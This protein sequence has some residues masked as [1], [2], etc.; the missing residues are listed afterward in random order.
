MAA[1]VVGTAIAVLLAA[2]YAAWRRYLWASEQDPEQLPDTC[3]YSLTDR[4]GP[5]SLIGAPHQKDAQWLTDIFSRSAKKY[6]NH[7]ALQI[8]LTGEQFTFAELDARAENI[9]AELSR[10]IDGPDQ[11]VAVAMSQDNWHIVAS[12]LAILKAGGTL[13]FLD[14]TLPESLI[15]H[16]LDDAKPVVILTRGLEQFRDLPTLDVL[17]VSQSDP[18]ADR[19]LP[20]WLDDPRERLATIFY[21]S[22][23]T[24]MPKGVECPHAGYVNLALTYAD[25][26]D[27]LPGMDATTLT[28]SL[29]YDGSISEMY[30]AWV[31]GCTVVLLTKEQVR[32]GPD[33][34]PILREAEVTVLFCPPVLL[35]T[36]TANPEIDL[37][38][39]I[40]RYIVP[41]GEAFPNALVE[42]WTRA[43]RQIINTYGPTEASTDTSRQ[44]LRPGEPI[45]IGSPFPNV[46]YVILEVDGLTP[47]PHGAEGELCIGGVHLAR[48]YRNLPE[49]TAQKF[50]THPQ[51]GRLYR[52]GDRCRIDPET[53]Q[54]H[55]LGRIDA[56]LKVRGH[57]VEAQA[58]EDIL[59]SQF[60]EI[61]AAVLD[62]QNEALVAF[63]LA[64]GVA[65]GPRPISVA[66]PAPADWAARVTAILSKQLPETS[67]PS[68]LFLVDGFVMKPVSGKIDR[69][70][71]PKLAALP[72]HAEPVAEAISQP[73]GSGDG[74]LTLTKPDVARITEIPPDAEE[75]LEICRSVFENNIELDDAFADAG[76][77]SIVIAR[78]AQRLHAA[79]WTIPVRALLSDCNTARKI[80]QRPRTQ[81]ADLEIISISNRNDGKKRIRDEAAAEVLSIPYFTALQIAFALLLYLPGFVAFLSL[82]GFLEI[83]TF[84]TSANIWAFI[85]VGF[86]VFVIGLA[87]PFAT[88]LWAM[89]VKLLLGGHPY[90]NNV[91]P[92]VY[93][94]WSRMHLRIWCIGRIQ[95]TVLMPL[96]AM[97][98]SAPLMAFALRQ[99][100]ATVGKNLQC[101]KEAAFYGPLDLISVGDDVAIQTGAYIHT[102]RWEGQ[103]LHV[104]PIRLDD[105]CKISMRAG[106]TS[107]VTI[108]KDAWITP[109][110]PIMSNVGPG[111]MWEGSPARATGR[112]V[113]LKRTSNVC[114]YT[115][116][117]WLLEV[118]NVFMQ[119]GIFFVLTVLPT[120]V[121][122]W[123]A[124]QFIPV[125][126][127]ELS[128]ASFTSFVATDQ[129]AA[130][131]T[132]GQG[133]VP[134]NYFAVTPLY[135]I[136]GHLALYAFATMW[137][138]IVT[139]SALIALFVRVTATSPGVYGVRGLRASLLIYRMGLLNQIQGIWTWTITGQYLRALAGLRFPR[140][141]ASEC[142]VMFNLVPEV[143]TAD[144]QVF[145]SNGSFT[146]TLDYGAEHVA[147]RQIDMPRNFFSG[148]NCVIEHG[149]FPDNFL[150]GVSTPCSDIIYRRQMRSRRA[151]PVTVAGNPPLQFASAS[152]EDENRQHRPPG[153]SLFLGRVLLNDVFSIG[154]LR[155]TEGLIFT[156]LYISLMRLGIDA[157]VGAVLALILAETGL[158]ILSVAVKQS[159]V[160][161]H[162]GTNHATPFWSWRHFT[163]FFAQDCFF[164]WCQGPLAF[165]AGTVLA[166]RVL[167]WLG[168]KVGPRTIVVDPMQCS[169]WNAVRF[170]DDCVVGG[171]LQFHTF[172]N[173][174]LKVKETHVGDGSV[175]AFGATVMSGAVIGR[176][177]TLQPL[178]MVLKEMNL[179]PGLYE[180]SPAEQS[181]PAIDHLKREAK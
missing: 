64:P 96:G 144:S 4:F 115:L 18:P 9:A 149:G 131:T 105:G 28:S 106:V 25:Y 133:A 93:P 107:E 44:S 85:I 119:I 98:R 127:A 110:T 12:H 38:Y 14:T 102:A 157:I 117:V 33:L 20:T 109:F 171:F 138:T 79:G 82:F 95:N 83:G 122:L 52:T 116:P 132:A 58:V 150:I 29:G 101:A 68:R 13:M 47:L 140:L 164:V 50:I 11:V 60:R 114:Q 46:T 154:L 72:S 8:P 63:V 158:I 94:K 49:Q 118:L 65:A 123:L 23:T 26:L 155:A 27:L 173:M 125:G 163:Y 69:K 136:F 99:L 165:L 177:T 34:V 146:N 30:S 143:A 142:D 179:P 2:I 129:P 77:H 137:L 120:A 152:F 70:C 88:L 89:F 176:D 43:R 181:R 147:L 97:Y 31:S 66:T 159:L 62:Y 39:P 178:S 22:G 172:E 6:P 17:T 51:F 76:G 5:N 1:L 84:F 167:R 19:V 91:T 32:S 71:L 48:G 37:P 145:W 42:P 108:G 160:G 90:K 180:G 10:F 174:M 162:W 35:T 80:A 16:M 153:F 175:V 81:R 3:P 75:V 41:A 113:K 92:G 59:Q 67:V 121:I 130:T 21:T 112:H 126:E 134:T 100:G 73:Q 141:G 55:F 111:E 86:G 104:G 135:L 166:N 148:N 40:C 36:L 15:T 74:V 156:L 161:N 151:K 103:S 170:G 61:E 24:G 53:Y 57:R 124:R 56:Q 7:V 139:T 87:V 168:C 78:L 54:V 45:T 169:D 128:G